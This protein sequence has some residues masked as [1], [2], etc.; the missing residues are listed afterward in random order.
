[1]KRFVCFLA[2]LACLAI[3]ALAA[4]VKL[5]GNVNVV[6][7]YNDT[8]ASLQIPKNE[9][10]NNLLFAYLH[11]LASPADYSVYL[12]LQFQCSDRTIEDGMPGIE[13][14]ISDVLVGTLFADGTIIG[15]DRDRF[16]LEGVFDIEDG[17]PYENTCEIRVGVKFWPDGEVVAGVRI[18]DY[19]GNPSNYYRQIVYSPY[20]ATT[21]PTEPAASRK[22]TTE[23][24]AATTT[25]SAASTAETTVRPARTTAPVITASPKRESTATTAAASVP[26]STTVHTEAV[27]S[28]KTTETK[29]TKP[30]TTKAKAAKAAATKHKKS[31]EPSSSGSATDAFAA[32]VV[33]GTTETTAPETASASASNAQT[34]SELNKVKIVGTVLV[35]VILTAAIM[36]S[37]FLG[38]RQKQGDAETHT[39]QEEYD[40][41]G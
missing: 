34:Y 1:M 3:T 36:S 14:Y 40:D 13:V 38:M 31:S 24:D 23:K 5:D 39:P 25:A 11:W 10:N 41:F 33:P 9:S 22:T 30:K 15:V 29:T 37:V 21:K 19:S 17:P 20:A 28:S 8:F 12:G 32:V 18:L 4:P 6:K 35:A 27:V 2:L 26:Q 16:E 7:E